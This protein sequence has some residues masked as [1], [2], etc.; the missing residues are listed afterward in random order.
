MNSS[1]DWLCNYLSTIVCQRL[2]FHACARGELFKPGALASDQRAWFLRIASVRECL[3][4][5]V[6]VCVRPRGY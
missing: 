2:L 6:C 5:C 1:F 4:T 3:Y